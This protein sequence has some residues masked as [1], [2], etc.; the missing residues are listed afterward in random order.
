MTTAEMMAGTPVI[1]TNGQSARIPM[2]ERSRQALLSRFTV[3]VPGLAA[4]LAQVPTS[5]AVMD[6]DA[7]IDIDLGQTRLYRDDGRAVAESQVLSYL[8]KPL[9]FFLVNLSGCNGGTWLSRQLTLFLTKECEDLGLEIKSLDVKPSYHGSYL[10]VLGVGLGFHL[11]KLISETNVRHVFLVEPTPEFLRHSLASIDWEYILTDGEARGITFS[12]SISSRPDRIVTEIQRMFINEGVSFIDGAFVFLHYPLWALKEARER[13]ADDLQVMYLSRGFYEDELIMMT[14]A[15]TN[16]MNYRYH[17]MDGKLR[18]KRNE[19]VFIVGSGPSIDNSL[20]YIKRW[21]DRVILFSCGT[22][23]RVCLKNGIIP[24]FHCEIENVPEVY[25]V[26]L[27]TSNEFDLSGITLIA[28]ITVDTRMAA[29]FDHTYFFFRDSV[30]ST[31]V[32]AND[33]LM[34]LGISPTVANTALRS[35]TCLGFTNL[36]LFGIDC[37]TKNEDNKHSRDSIYHTLG[38]MKDAD[39]NHKF[40][41]TCI[42]NF[43]GTVQTHWIF[44]FSK[45]MLSAFIKAY[46]IKAYNC[47]DGASIDGALPKVAA[48]I[49]IKGPVLDRKAIKYALTG[50]LVNYEPHEYLK[51]FFDVDLV[52]H[53]SRFYQDI[54]DV[55]DQAIAHDKDFVAFWRRLSTFN[56]QINNSYHGIESIPIGTILSLPKIG[57][58]FVHRV[59]DTKDRA[60]IFSAFLAEYRRIHEFM[61]DGTLALLNDVSDRI[62]YVK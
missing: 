30:S 51:P 34:I 23:L 50:C 49:E 47:S 26:A 39:N 3:S 15:T 41:D 56:D 5:V 55:I 16:M 28:S 6:G 7:V 8:E 17:L 38:S 27:A 20:Q 24:D 2:V 37:G 53:A 32:L 33:Q 4:E 46:R 40:P 10:V 62:K 31:R 57:M 11:K 61:R 59:P 58:F 54:I 25:D 18:P 48:S 9:R 44:H 13:L 1:T 45:F 43:G 42:G 52:E 21:R 36:Y 19:P 35:A 22:G 12:L 14:N 60:I 29:L